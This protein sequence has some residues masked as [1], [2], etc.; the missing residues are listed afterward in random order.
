MPVVRWEPLRDLV[1]L[2]NRVNRILGD[3][4][5]H[6]L[7]EESLTGTIHPPVDIYECAD[8]LVLEADVPGMNLE[9]LDIRVEDNTLTI[10]GERKQRQDVPEGSYHRAERCY[11]VFTR[12]F[13]LPNT[14]DAGKIQAG[15]NNGVLRLTMAKREESKPR[16]IKVQVGR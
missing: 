6:V 16:Q 3:R 12:S 13:S 4:L 9:D 5:G 2:Q 1:A 15:Y 10:Q 8:E 14:I 11:G 7:G